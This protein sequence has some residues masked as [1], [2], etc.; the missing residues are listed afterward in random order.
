MRARWA[1][2]AVVALVACGSGPAHVTPDASSVS[3]PPTNATPLVEV[4]FDIQAD[5]LVPGNVAT[6]LCCRTY[7]DPPGRPLVAAWAAP[8]GV[9][10]GL[11][12]VHRL[13]MAR[14]EPEAYPQ[15]YFRPQTDGSSWM[16][17][18]YGLSE[19]ERNRLADEVTLVDGLFALPDAALRLVGAGVE[20]DGTGTSQSY[21]ADDGAVTLAVGGYRGQLEQFAESGTLRTV[22]VAGITGVAVG[23]ERAA[24]VVWPVG[25]HLW[26]TLQFSGQI[27]GRVDEVVA[28]VAPADPAMIRPGVIEHPEIAHQYRGV[29]WVIEMPGVVPKIVFEWAASLPPQGGDVPLAGW[30]WNSVVGEESLNGTTWGGPWE[31][32]G[33]WDGTTVTV[34]QPPRPGTS[35]GSWRSALGAPTPNCDEQTLLPARQ[36]L[37][38]IGQGLV[39]WIDLSVDLF[40]GNC[41]IRVTA[42]LPSTELDAALA[43]YADVI[44]SVD[45]VFEPVT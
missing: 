45:Y 8:S 42:L 20:G 33:T 37:R 14:N 5:G 19:A 15:R 27:A 41:G 9:Q 3:T 7:V 24:T 10:D 28:A 6:A 32:V 26:G 39:G 29:V 2:L 25:D 17:E 40:D 22:T 13:P 35:A 44:L 34:T 1:P 30:D 43:K 23:G 31:V 21:V 11:L 16:F 4:W 36:A 12:L 18:S 38:P